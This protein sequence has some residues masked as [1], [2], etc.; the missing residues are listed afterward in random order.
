MKF[1]NFILY[2]ILTIKQFDFISYE[3]KCFQVIKKLANL[4]TTYGTIQ[5]SFESIDKHIKKSNLPIVKQIL[6]E[7]DYWDIK[8]SSS[9][10]TLKIKNFEINQLIQLIQNGKSYYNPFNDVI[11]DQTIRKFKNKIRNV[12]ILG[13]YEYE[14]A[15]WIEAV[16]LNL[17]PNAQV[18]IID[19]QQKEY[20]NIFCNNVFLS[21]GVT[22]KIIFINSLS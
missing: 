19:Y 7:H 15:P 1:L 6:I 3:K 21:T 13:L 20:E 9:K 14:Y 16:L 11:L 22:P 10:S 5:P 8:N 4:H 17:N 18:T 12:A 2:F